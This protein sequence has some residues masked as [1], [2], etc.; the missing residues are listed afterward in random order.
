M[1][2]FRE[3]QVIGVAINS[4]RV[5]QPV[6]DL[7]TLLFGLLLFLFGFFLL[8]LFLFGFLLFSL[9]LFGL[10][11]FG[12]ALLLRLFGLLLFG[13]LLG[14]TLLCLLLFGL[15]LGYF[16]FGLL[17]LGLLFLLCHPGGSCAGTRTVGDKS[18][19]VPSGESLNR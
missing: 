9:L 4:G 5:N 13:L 7:A 8:S 6:I 1:V 12:L 2:S 17:L 16:T 10:L 14:L 19:T 11:L 3:R 15:A 18:P